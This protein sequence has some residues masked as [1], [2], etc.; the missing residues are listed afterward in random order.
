MSAALV[1]ETP[2]APPTYATPRDPKASTRGGRTGVIAAALGTPLMPWQQYVADV[3]LERDPTDPARWRYPVVVITVPRQ[4]GKTTLLRAMAVERAI[5]APHQLIFATA[6][7]GKDA[8]E[9][10]KDMVSRVEQSALRSKIRVYKGAGAM[11]MIL[12]NGSQ[13]R[14]FAPTPK[15]IHGYT[16]HM[17]M[18]D[19]AWAFDAAQGEDLMAAIRPSQITLRDRQLVIV[20][21]AGTKDSAFLRSWV[22]TGR[23]AVNDP[24]S[25]IAYFEW[26]A[27]EGQDAYDSATWAFHPALGHTITLEDLGAEAEGATRGNF[28]RA[29]MNRWTVNTETALD[30]DAWDARKN[31]EQQPPTVRPVLAYDVAQDQ[32]GATIHAGWRDAAGVLQLRMVATAAGV[33][34]LV[35]MVTRLRTEMNPRLIGADDGGPCRAVTDELRLSGVEVETLGARD[36]GT[37]CTSLSQHLT[38]GTFQHDGAPETRAAIQALA[39]KYLADQLAWDRRK[40]TGPIDALVSL[41][42]AARLVDHGAPAMPKPEVWVP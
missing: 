1:E 3:A 42:V 9:R 37:A 5:S 11:S 12:P 10:W 13:V 36:Y 8:G 32:S 26:S 17:V 27:P 34:W 15:S 20:S 21:T 22:D 14:S 35:P 18:I 7:T 40:S 28:E 25:G 16:P 30:L 19:E 4:S 6:Q 38:R 33:D 29:Y 41:T 2:W 31:P 23:L 39:T 24:S